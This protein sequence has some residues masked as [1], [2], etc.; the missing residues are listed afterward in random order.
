[1]LNNA[2]D[3][4]VAKEAPGEITIRSW[5]VNDDW[6][7]VAI[8]DNG[9]GIDANTQNKIFDPFFTNKPVGKGTGLGLS[10]CYQ[11]V[12]QGHGGQIYCK[13]EPGKGSEFIVEL[14]LRSQILEQKE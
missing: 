1:L 12:V 11:V 7:G 5:Q 14:P 8:Q 3:A 13:S 4:L 9:I 2:F 6:I 10:T